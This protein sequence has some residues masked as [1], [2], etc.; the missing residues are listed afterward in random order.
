L[1]ERAARERGIR[2]IRDCSIKPR[3]DRRVYRLGEEYVAK[4]YAPEAADLH[5]RERTF[6]ELNAGSG[7][8]PD[9]VDC[10]F[11]AQIGG[12]VIITGLPGQALA[13]LSEGVPETEYLEIV[14]DLGTCIATIHGVPATKLSH[15]PSSGLGTERRRHFSAMPGI[16]D[17]LRAENLL[18]GEAIGQ[19]K[20]AVKR[21][22]EA[23]F[24]SPRILLHGDVHSGNILV[25]HARGRWRCT[26][27][28][29][30]KSGPDHMELE[31]VFPFVSVLGEAFPGR[32]LAGFWNAIWQRLAQGYAR[33]GGALPDQGLIA[34]HA[35]AWC[36]GV[37]ADS[38]D[39][40]HPS[41]RK[42]ANFALD[43]LSVYRWE[44]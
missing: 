14:E 39:E 7:R 43:A 6:L 18:P 33:G 23:A 3:P 27:I 38:L 10:G 11:D 20:E 21:A 41:A 22:Q 31:F 8:C 24:A 44:A 17:R 12:Y 19:L 40:G 5:R 15:L 34:G 28:D 1:V 37:S 29:F 25:T 42:F 13:Q 26:L 32:R 36:L 4:L 16:A 9:L 35:I 30:E 2:S